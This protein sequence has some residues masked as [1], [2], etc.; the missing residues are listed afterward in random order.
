MIESYIIDKLKELV[1]NTSDNK[2]DGIGNRAIKKDI[3]AVLDKVQ[4]LN[5]N[6]YQAVTLAYYLW[7]NSDMSLYDYTVLGIPDTYMRAVETLVKPPNISHEEYLR[8]IVNNDYAYQV[9]LSARTLP[10]LPNL[11]GFK[12]S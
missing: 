7:I 10:T 1:D 11:F 9:W 6:A 2:V 12:S 3:Y 8:G 5:D 4:Q